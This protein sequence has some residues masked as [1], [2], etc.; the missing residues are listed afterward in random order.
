MATSAPQ[1][2]R[3]GVAESSGRARLKDRDS[4]SSAGVAS[5]HA[6]D[7]RERANTGGGGPSARARLSAKKM[8]R[9]SGG[10]LS[11]RQQ[12]PSKLAAKLAAGA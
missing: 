10:P 2:P 3:H 1:P 8:P 7:Q 6:V 5:S 11:A 4:P 9:P 12:P